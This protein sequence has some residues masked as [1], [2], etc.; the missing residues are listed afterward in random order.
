[1]ICSFQ[2]TS[3]AA[4]VL[5]L[6]FVSSELPLFLISMLIGVVLDQA[7][8]RQPHCWDVMCITPQV[9]RKHNFRA[10]FL[11]LWLSKYFTSLSAVII[12]WALKFRN[13]VFYI[14]SKILLIVFIELQKTHYEKAAEDKW[15]LAFQE[16]YE[17]WK[18]IKMIM[19]RKMTP[20]AQSL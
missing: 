16:K 8:Y 1:M 7:I 12:D 5:C 6:G 2:W 18:D 3:L 14:S 9:S 10:N 4:L 19:M 11:F 17:T 13:C 15:R 20:N